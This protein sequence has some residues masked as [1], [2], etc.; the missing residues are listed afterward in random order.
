MSLDTLLAVA[1]TVGVDSNNP[2]GGLHHDTPD[3]E[4]LE[5][6][7]DIANGEPYKLGVHIDTLSAKDELAIVSAFFNGAYDN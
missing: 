6:I 4:I 1:H 7:T 2:D 3:H 5:V